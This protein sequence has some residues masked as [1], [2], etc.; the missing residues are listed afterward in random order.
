M[1]VLKENGNEKINFVY[2]T[3]NLINGKGYYHIETII[4]GMGIN[5]NSN[6]DGKSSK[7]SFLV[8][9]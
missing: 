2:L 8:N 4:N 6:R 9:I 1:S 5:V 7:S 3:I